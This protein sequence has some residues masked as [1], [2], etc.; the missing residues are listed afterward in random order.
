M[1]KKSMCALPLMDLCCNQLCEHASFLLISIKNFISCLQNDCLTLNTF[2]CQRKI[3]I[4]LKKKTTFKNV[5]TLAGE[6]AQKVGD[7]IHEIL[8]QFSQITVSTY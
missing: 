6:N 5:P 2:I 8:K 3:Q 1:I 7:K 4:M